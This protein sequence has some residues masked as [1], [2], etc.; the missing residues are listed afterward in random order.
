MVTQSTAISTVY[1]LS[2]CEKEQTSLERA[3]GA[4]KASMLKDSWTVDGTALLKAHLSMD[5]LKAGSCL[6]KTMD[7]W[8]VLT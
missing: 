1:W 6:E 7:V 3:M 2:V 4:S 5:E 8:M